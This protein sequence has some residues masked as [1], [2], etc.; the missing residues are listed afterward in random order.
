MNKNAKVFFLMRSFINL[1]QV[2]H[3]LDNKFFLSKMNN[4]E[5]RVQQLAY[6]AYM[7]TPTFIGISMILVMH[8]L[9][10]TLILSL[11]FFKVFTFFLVPITLTCLKT[12]CHIFD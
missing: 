8:T 4:Y 2:L 6:I 10:Y 7:C 9:T 5:I 12:Y 3:N 1:Q 11:W